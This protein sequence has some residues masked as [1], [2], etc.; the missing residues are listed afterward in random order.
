MNSQM[1][2]QPNDILKMESITG[3]KPGRWIVSGEVEW[4]NDELDIAIFGTPNQE[5]AGAC[6]FRY[7]NDIG[8]VEKLTTIS[9]EGLA[10]KEQI[11]RYKDTLANIISHLTE[12]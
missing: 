3:F 9:F 7:M 4:Y 6:Q 5:E 1:Y 12:Q 11:A 10:P 8:G 2:L